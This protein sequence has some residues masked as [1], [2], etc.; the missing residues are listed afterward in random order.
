LQKIIDKY[1]SIPENHYINKK[2]WNH[3]EEVKHWINEQLQIISHKLPTLV[4]ENPASFACGYNMGYKQC[5]LTLD[6]IL[7]D[8]GR[9]IN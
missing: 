6:R 2:G 3:M 9:E 7:E 4:H 5:L 8:K 1:N